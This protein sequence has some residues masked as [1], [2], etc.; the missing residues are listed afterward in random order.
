MVNPETQTIL[1]IRHIKKTKGMEKTH[2]ETKK[3]SYLYATKK[4]DVKQNIDDTRQ[5]AI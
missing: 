1:G 2:T 4:P 5:R 3:M